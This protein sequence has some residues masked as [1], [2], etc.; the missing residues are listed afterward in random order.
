MA[1]FA[2]TKDLP[3][4]DASEEEQEAATYQPEPAEVDA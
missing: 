3:D 1:L 4:S 2:K